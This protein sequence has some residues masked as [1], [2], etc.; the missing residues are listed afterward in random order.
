MN[1]SKLIKNQKILRLFITFIVIIPFEVLSFYSIHFP[2]WVELP[3][4]LAIAI[5]Y[6]K[7]VFVSGIKSLFRLNFSDINL[8][9]TIAIFG[10]VY[11]SKFEEAVTIV[12]LFALANAL[13][14]FGIERSQDALK[15]LVAKTPKSAF[16]KGEKEKTLI[17]DIEVGDVLIIRP[18]DYIS[19]DGEIIKGSSLI[20]ETTITGE[21]L[22]RNKHEGD[23][24][25]AGTINTN[26][27]LEIKVTKSVKDTTLAKI[28]DITYQSAEKKSQSQKFI[29]KF[30]GFYTPFVIVIALLIVVVPVVF[31]HQPF[32]KWFAE[33]LTLLIISCPCALVVSTPVSIFSAVGSA[34]KKGIV[35]KG[36]RFLEE[37][38][39]IK[40]VAF[41]KTRTLTEGK[42]TVS[43][44]VPFN[45]S[46]QE[47]LLA[48][49]AG[50]E[51]LSSHP[52]AKSIVE[53]AQE[54]KMTPHK[55]KD[56]KQIAGGG[57]SGECMVCIDKHHC[58]GNMRFISKEHKIQ[59]EVLKKVE[60]FEKEGK[61]TVVVSDDKSVA[62][63]IGITDVIRAESKFAIESLLKLKIVPVI[64]TGD[65][66]SSAVYVAEKIGVKQVDAGL[67][68]EE[69]VNKLKALMAKYKH[70]A[71]VGDGVNDA[72]ALAT[73]SI[74][75]AMG[76]V[77]SD[78]AVEN[79]DIALM[80]DNVSYIPYLVKLGRNTT[81]TIQ[82]N[83]SVAVVVK[84]VF[85]VLALVGRSDLTMAIF[86]D[87]GITF[88]VVL[89]S[90]RL[91]N[92]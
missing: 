38:G 67:L 70:V 51:S 34:T 15:E 31:L 40:A 71:M 9:M 16:I 1:I 91:F 77:G 32:D 19:L 61:T 60:E 50:I 44:V 20:D 24:V 53:K 18:G 21:P 66:K 7:D 22:P 35:I 46:T 28:I 69:K 54:G 68:P 65:N 84:L 41:D 30:A 79:A 52:L 80:S 82:L 78:V 75:V 74:G 58:I 12:I 86:A 49:V 11:L 64:L 25:Y 63:V 76:A 42:P 48:C 39:K 2:L 88:I 73:A 23:V 87:V 59:Q 45:G 14:D 56:F 90:L 47:G 4:F 8:L 83:T 6:G 5:I 29:E 62:G 55:F 57:I 85:I 72:P 3:I 26:G 10:A 92:K 17:E 89:N 33:A 43:D 37:M 27:Y 36:G 13:E 81:K